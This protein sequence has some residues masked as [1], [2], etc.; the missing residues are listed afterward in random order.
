MHLNPVRTKQIF[1]NNG[2]GEGRFDTSY[3]V[4]ARTRVLK[5]RDLKDTSPKNTIPN[6]HES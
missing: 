2:P 5:T 4:S 1:L 3:S 6:G